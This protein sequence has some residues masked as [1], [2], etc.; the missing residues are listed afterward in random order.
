MSKLL[1]NKFFIYVAGLQPALSDYLNPRNPNLMQEFVRFSASK[2]L[3]LGDYGP[4]MFI[5]GARAY[6]QAPTLDKMNFLYTS[7]VYDDGGRYIGG[8]DQM[9]NLPKDVASGVK[10]GI[11]QFMKD[12]GNR[13]GITLTQ[14]SDNMS[15]LPPGDLFDRALSVTQLD[16][17]NNGVYK[18]SNMYISRTVLG[19]QVT[20]IPP[21][22]YNGNL[23]GV[24]ETIIAMQRL[25]FSLPSPLLSV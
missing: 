8:N 18:H 16:V 20:R 22:Q 21:S 12:R 9:I 5:F 1:G 7:F 14:H 25:G 3:N 23:T 17:G 15:K 13:K 19:W 4:L 6:K 2:N 10:N 11:E 24:R